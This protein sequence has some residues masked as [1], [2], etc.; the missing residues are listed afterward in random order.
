MENWGL[1]LYRVV[2]LLFDET[3]YSG[4]NTKLRVTEGA[5]NALVGT[6]SIEYIPLTRISVGPVMMR[7]MLIVS[8]SYSTKT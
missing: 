8:P 3:L 6:K 5:Q 4:T 1:V 7:V 2:D